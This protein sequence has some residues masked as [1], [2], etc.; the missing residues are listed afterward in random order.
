MRSI[1]IIIICL[2]FIGM[3]IAGVAEEKKPN[4]QGSEFTLNEFKSVIS[5]HSKP[6]WKD[7][8]E[9]L[10]K[11]VAYFGL[12]P[13]IPVLFAS[14]TYIHQGQLKMAEICANKA[15]KINPECADAYIL[16]AQLHDKNGSIKLADED[17][18]KSIALNPSLFA[19]KKRAEFYVSRELYARAIP[20]LQK[21]LELF[22]ADVRSLYWLG[23][24]YAE[25][26]EYDKANCYLSQ[27][28]SNNLATASFR[29]AAYMDRG[30]VYVL[31]GKYDY[32]MSDFNALIKLRSDDAARYYYKAMLYMK[33]GDLD[34]AE[35]V[36]RRGL[37]IEST[38]RDLNNLLDK[39]INNQKTKS[40]EA[41]SSTPTPTIKRDA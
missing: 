14:E 16:R 41:D 29:S 39:I 19:Y 24:S 4:G 2:L 35:E 31:S 18:S 32:A 37:L 10:N 25:E 38:Q 9:A 36:C 11:L 15:I 8:E 1:R 26:S 28:I 20:D 13:E 12:Y 6:E 33:T 40:G 34:K 5:G 23:K 17:Y 3:N 30:L 7:K 27:V 22:P 21:A